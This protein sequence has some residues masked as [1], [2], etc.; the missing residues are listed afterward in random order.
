MARTVQD[1]FGATGS[2]VDLAFCPHFTDNFIQRV[3]WP[4]K[5]G[6]GCT[7]YCGWQNDEIATDQTSARRA[8][9]SRAKAN[10]ED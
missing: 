7:H 4:G 2:L 5:H 8:R 10:R 6:N 1:S 3:C 9:K